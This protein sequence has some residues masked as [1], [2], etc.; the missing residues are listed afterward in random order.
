MYDIL[1]VPCFRNPGRNA[2]S[3]Y[4]GSHNPI[5]ADRHPANIRP[6]LAN[7]FYTQQNSF[8]YNLRGVN[9]SKIKV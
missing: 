6:P 9:V 2:R 5:R 4:P 1:S 3:R 7:A 8:V